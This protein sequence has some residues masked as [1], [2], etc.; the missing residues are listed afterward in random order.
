MAYRFG[1]F[2]LDGGTRRLV[3]DDTEVHLSPKA[4]VLLSVLVANR[5]RAVSKRE[6]LDLIWPSSFVEE[7]NLA[8]LVL[9]I[10]RALDDTAAMPKLIRTIHGFGYHFIGNVVE[11]RAATADQPFRER[12]WLTF[13]D[14]DFPL[15]EG[16]QVIGRAPEN[17]VRIDLP[18]VSRHHARI[19]VAGRQATIEDLDSKNGTLVNGQPISSPVLLAEADEIRIG[20][21][22]L[23]FRIS[24]AASPTATIRA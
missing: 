21:A 9:E 11:A 23:R 17:A 1:A 15:M 20:G 6:L 18:G 12:L 19:A 10:R 3:R 8:G 2:T 5:A 7:T 16:A 4:F 13:R 14:H 22:I 24:S